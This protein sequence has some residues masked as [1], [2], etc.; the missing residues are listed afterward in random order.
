M[1]DAEVELLLHANSLNIFSLNLKLDAQ[2]R[3]QIGAL[4]DRSA[5]PDIPGQICQF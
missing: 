5:H 1:E 4:H 3:P 2:R